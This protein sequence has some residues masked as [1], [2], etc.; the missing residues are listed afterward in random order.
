MNSTQVKRS[1]ASLVEHC[2][3]IKIYVVDEQNNLFRSDIDSDALDETREQFC[4]SLKRK[5][6]NHEN[7]SSPVLSLHDDRKNALYQFDFDDK[8]DE[9]AL[10]EQAVAVRADNQPPV[11]QAR[12]NKLGSI[13][14]LIIVLKDSNGVCTAFYQHVFSVSILRSERKM[15]SMAV[16]ETRLIPL[17]TDILRISEN[18]VFMLHAGTFFIENVTALENQLNFKEAVHARAAVYA[19]DIVAL[20]YA[21]NFDVFIEKISEETAFARKVIKVCRHSAVLEK[22]ITTADLIRF[23]EDKPV[24]SDVLRLNEDNTKFDLNSINRCKKFLQLLDDDFLVS[25]LTDSSYIAKVKDR[26]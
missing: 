13:K 2:D 5:Y 6:T 12:D 26:T 8:P 14:A 24:Y 9:F 7:F 18:F 25:P 11:Y 19:E 22:N 20:S 17:N 4:D 1:L 10:L 21:D 3:G 23:I 15:L 16:H